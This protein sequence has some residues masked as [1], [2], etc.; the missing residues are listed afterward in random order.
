MC[1]NQMEPLEFKIQ[2]DEGEYDLKAKVTIIGKDFLVAIWGG[3]KPHIGAVSVAQPRPSRNDPERIS[4]T[5]SVFCFLGHKEDDLAKATAEVLS[6]ALNAN[7]VVSAG[8]HWENIDPSGI[9]KVIQNSKII[10]K[11]ILEKAAKKLT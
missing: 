3:D 11:K 1:G 5:A 10:V 6:A 2:T 8:I 9:Q 4:S 7:V